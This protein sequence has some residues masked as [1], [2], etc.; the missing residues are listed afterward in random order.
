LHNV[1]I[2]KIA[3]I[4]VIQLI[5]FYQVLFM[6]LVDFLPKFACTIETI[7]WKT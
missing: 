5:L 7:G 4:F 3:L 2:W 6:L 1:L